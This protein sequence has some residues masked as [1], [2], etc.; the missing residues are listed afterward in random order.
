MGPGAFS[1]APFSSG[2]ARP[3]ELAG[4]AAAA[5]GAVVALVLGGAALDVGT[6]GFAMGPG[7]SSRASGLGSADSLAASFSNCCLY[8]WAA[9]EVYCRAQAWSAVPRRL[10]LGTAWVMQGMES[11]RWQSPCNSDVPIFH[12][13]LGGIRLRA[14]LSLHLVWYSA[15]QAR[16]A[17]TPCGT[18]EADSA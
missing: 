11:R 18:T 2:T 5:R 15:M 8:L 12:Q 10:H 3:L 6:A 16:A 4:A 14:C 9:W 7:A 1:T 13:L 17:M